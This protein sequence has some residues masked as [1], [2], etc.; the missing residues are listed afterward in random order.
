MDLLIKPA[1]YDKLLEFY[2][3]AKENFN[4]INMDFLN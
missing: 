1:P 3:T 2:R 4:G